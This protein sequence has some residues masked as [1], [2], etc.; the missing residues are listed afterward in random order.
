MALRSLNNTPPPAIDHRKKPA[1]ITGFLINDENIAPSSTNVASNGRANP[2][3]AKS[4]CEIPASD[5]G[6]DYIASKNLPALPDPEA[7]IQSLME[8][9]E[10]K[11]WLTMCEALNN[12]RRLALYHSSTLLPLIEK[13]VMVLVKGL[14]NPR[15][16]VCKTSIMASS[17]LF[18]S[19]PHI[20]FSTAMLLQLLLKASQ[21]KKFVCEEAEKA[22]QA[23][24]SFLPGLPLLEKVRPL[25][26]HTNLRV[27][28]KAAVSFCNCVTK[29]ES[30]DIKEFGCSGHLQ[31]AA[32]LLND[33]LPEAREA[34]RKIAT[35][36]YTVFT[37]EEKEE[38]TA[39][40]QWQSFC[41]SNLP[42]LS[43]QAVSKL[44]TSQ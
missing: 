37:S 6:I 30:G 35:T 4:N 26:G 11:D 41:F 3:V 28:A 42:P 19:F 12:T 33:R 21:D 22:L 27:R 10:S 29:M 36:V 23:M 32:D 1:K 43:A 5:Q 34:A 18:H 13:V 24:S 25:V 16:A 17:D 15:S 14:K 20:F 40:E 8:K 39:S 44:I 38:T 31:V 9:L 2:P 7:N